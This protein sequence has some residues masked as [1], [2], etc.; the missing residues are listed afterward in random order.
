MASLPTYMSSIDNLS[1]KVKETRNILVAPVYSHLK[2]WEDP[3]AKR[4]PIAIFQLINKVDFKSITE[5]D[6]VS[7][8]LFIL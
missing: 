5:F 3:K 6:V 8:W 1:Q 2:E 7:N 4:H